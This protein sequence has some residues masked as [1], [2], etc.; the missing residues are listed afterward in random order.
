MP[1][2]DTV[3]QPLSSNFV[4][5]RPAALSSMRARALSRGVN[6]RSES[7][8][9]RSTRHGPSSRRRDRDGHVKVGTGMPFWIATSPP[10]TET[11][12]SV[13]RS[14][15][16]SPV[17]TQPARAAVTPMSARGGPRGATEGPVTASDL[18]DGRQ[19]RRGARAEG[20]GRGGRD[21]A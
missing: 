19:P 18:P 16:A 6:E 17:G 7:N 8:S 20:A 13:G 10:W 1:G 12:V 21:A 9:W 5:W 15:P 14:W 11:I 2:T 4:V 3:S